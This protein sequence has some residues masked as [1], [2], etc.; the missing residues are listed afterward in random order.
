M[1]HNPKQHEH[2]R[3]NP[4]TGEKIVV[5]AGHTPQVKVQTSLVHRQMLAIAAQRHLER[6]IDW[7]ATGTLSSYETRK[8][9]PRLT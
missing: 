4:R 8:P 3:T 9:V 5:N 6:N 7:G 2:T 1:A